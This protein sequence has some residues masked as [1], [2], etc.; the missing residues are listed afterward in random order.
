MTFTIYSIL[1]LVS[2]ICL[3]LFGFFVITRNIRSPINQP[4]FLLCFSTGLWALGYSFMYA[5]HT[6]AQALFWARF[7]YLGVIY[8]PI[9][10]YHF[11]VIFLKLRGHAPFLVSVYLS[12]IA[13]IIASR[14]G[15]FLTGIK[16]V[17]FKE[18]R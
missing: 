5:S 11:T 7:G 9:S 10:L 6:E 17:F 4:F 15:H 3:F 18:P 1:P 2:S 14:T 8:I 12:S 13:W 16:M